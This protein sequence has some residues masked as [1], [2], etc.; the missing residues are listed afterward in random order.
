[1]IVVSS[2]YVF[3]PLTHPPLGK[4]LL[5]QRLTIAISWCILQPYR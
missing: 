5:T 1:M 3:G 4:A 2:L